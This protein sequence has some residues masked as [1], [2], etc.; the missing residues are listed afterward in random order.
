MFNWRRERQFRY[1]W[2][3]LINKN[4]GKSKLNTCVYSPAFLLNIYNVTRHFILVSPCLLSHNGCYSLKLW[5]KKILVCL[6]YLCHLYYHNNDKITNTMPTQFT[7]IAR[8]VLLLF[9]KKSITRLTITITNQAQNHCYELAHWNLHSISHLLEHL[10]RSALANPKLQ[11]LHDTR[12]QHISKQIIGE[13]P[14]SI[15]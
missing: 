6:S 5:F 4:N 8:F 14:A 9:F 2:C 15:V 3:P 10:K 11:H 1:G 12:E 13:G 7:C